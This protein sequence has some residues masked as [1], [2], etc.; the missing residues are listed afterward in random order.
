MHSDGSNRA[1]STL[2][3]GVAPSPRAEEHVE[4]RVSA[5][6]HSRRF[7][8]ASGGYLRWAARSLTWIVR[9]ESAMRRSR[10]WSLRCSRDT[11]RRVEPRGAFAGALCRTVD[12]RADTP[13][14]RVTALPRVW[15]S[16]MLPHI[17]VFDWRCLSNCAHPPGAK[18]GCG[19]EDSF[20]R[21]SWDCPCSLRDGI[22]EARNE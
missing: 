3:Q 12:S 7:L 10:T 14:C 9:S 2:D 20:N 6:R 17:T 19:P 5:P 21:V 18:V 16:R 1:S 11:T 13:L 8:C 4:S 22:D 15:S